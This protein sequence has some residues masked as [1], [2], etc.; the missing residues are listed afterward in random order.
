MNQEKIGKFI[1][2]RREQQKLKQK[3]LADKLG[4]TNK[5]ISKWENG[6]GMPD[7]TLF[8]KLCQALDISVSELL[9][10][11]LDNKNNLNKEEA[12]TNYIS[13]KETKH[14]HKKIMVIA[15]L[16]LTTIVL[17]LSIYFINS[18]KKI[19]IYELSG[20]SENF[21]YENGL[22][23]KSN[24]KS[25][26]ELGKLTSSTI[27]TN[28]IVNQNLSVKIGKEYYF[29]SNIK[30]GEVISE[31]Y[32]Y[33]EYIR[34]PMLQYIP[35][36]LYILIWYKVDNQIKLETIKVSSEK[37]LINDK[38]VYKKSVSIDN[39]EL[40]EPINLNQYDNYQEY[41][42]F[43]YKEGF[44][45]PI[46]NNTLCTA[47]CLEKQISNTEYI[48][49]R[50]TNK[51]FYYTKKEKDIRYDVQYIQNI[52]DQGMLSIMGIKKKDK[53]GSKRFLYD[54]NTNSMTGEPTESELK[55]INKIINEYTK[56]VQ[57]SS[58]TYQNI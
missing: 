33:N 46:K 49:I 30:D 57:V 32:G 35:E 11:E 10:G 4:V 27:N 34:E 18:Y 22:L 25:I 2:Q 1:A 14:K 3:D 39:G 8:K 53:E 56:Y 51:F 29:I 50:P 16:I 42:D 47:N 44:K 45:E 38:I 24:I 55:V 36:N 26:L 43:L 41:K 58:D 48:A 21:K 13:Y 17:T 52:N 40:G 20:K 9:N 5:A 15:I 19:T 7:Y 37:L 54:F 6:R 28:Q 23:V 12:L 31:N